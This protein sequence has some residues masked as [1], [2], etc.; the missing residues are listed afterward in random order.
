MALLPQHITDRLKKAGDRA[1]K[2]RAFDGVHAPRTQQYLALI[3]E[4]DAATQEARE[5][6]PHLYRKD[7]A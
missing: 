7:T 4:I 3:A 6:L 5:S 1:Y 2:L